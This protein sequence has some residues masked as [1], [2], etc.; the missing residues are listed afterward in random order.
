MGIDAHNL[1]G[2]EIFCG[3]HIKIVRIG[4]VAFCVFLALARPLWNAFSVVLREVCFNSAR[5]SLEVVLWFA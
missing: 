5:W 2:R 3:A 4:V 1:K